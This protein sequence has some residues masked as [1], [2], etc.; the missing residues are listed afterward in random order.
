M[1]VLSGDN[2]RHLPSQSLRY[3]VKLMLNNF[4]IHISLLKFWKSKF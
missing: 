3:H 1:S 4:L 2:S